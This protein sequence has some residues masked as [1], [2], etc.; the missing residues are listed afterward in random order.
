MSKLEIASYEGESFAEEP[1]NREEAGF[2]V[3]K[4]ITFIRALI[5]LSYGDRVR[6]SP[7]ADLT[8]LRALPAHASLANN[9][10]HLHGP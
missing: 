8:S 6:I 4:N 1:A 2:F 7:T 10:N 3:P 9:L 5:V